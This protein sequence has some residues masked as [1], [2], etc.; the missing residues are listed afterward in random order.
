MND[1]RNKKN[2]P[3]IHKGSLSKDI[4]QATNSRPGKGMDKA[5]GYQQ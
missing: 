5:N 1:K 3:A 2:I 4:R